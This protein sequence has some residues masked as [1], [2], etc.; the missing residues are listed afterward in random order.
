MR[1]LSSSLKVDDNGWHVDLCIGGMHVLRC[2]RW[3][4]LLIWCWRMMMMHVLTLWLWNHQN[5]NFGSYVPSCVIEKGTAV[6]A[7]NIFNAGTMM[8]LMME[9]MILM[10]CWCHLTSNTWH[11]LTHQDVFDNLFIHVSIIIFIVVDLGTLVLWC[12][13]YRDL[14]QGDVDGNYDVSGRRAGILFYVDAI[15]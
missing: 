10:V 14:S 11:T 1:L 5:F 9:W 15:L 3:L 12:C 2:H 7:L 13:R 4:S 8:L 6:D